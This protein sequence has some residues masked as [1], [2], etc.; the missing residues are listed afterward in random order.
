MAAQAGALPTIHPEPGQRHWVAPPSSDLSCTVCGEVYSREAGHE[1][2]AHS[3]CNPRELLGLTF[4]R[5]RGLCNSARHPPVRP[6]LLPRL[7][8]RV[9]QSARKY[10]PRL[11]QRRVP[12]RQ[13]RTPKIL[14]Q[15]SPLTPRAVSHLWERMSLL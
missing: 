4:L 1:V 10:V 9:D 5:R 2:R 13:V 7:R 3:A 6:H 15:P 14:V 8:H 12:G 11:P